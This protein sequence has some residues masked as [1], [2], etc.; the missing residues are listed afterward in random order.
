MRKFLSGKKTYIGFGLF[1]AYAALV[2]FAGVQSEEAV[3]GAIVA[4]TGVSGVLHIDK[5]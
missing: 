1:F 3:W 4:F 5:K 2:Q